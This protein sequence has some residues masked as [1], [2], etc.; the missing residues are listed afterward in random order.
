MKVLSTYYDESHAITSSMLEND[1][2]TFNIINWKTG[3]SKFFHNNVKINCESFEIIKYYLSD[4]T[5]ILIGHDKFIV[6]KHDKINNRNC[7]VKLTPFFEENFSSLSFQYK[8]I[9]YTK[10]GKLHYFEDGKSNVVDFDYDEDY[11]PN[12]IFRKGDNLL[13]FN[14]EHR[15]DIFLMTS[16]FKPRGKFISIINPYHHKLT[17]NYLCCSEKKNA[18]NEWTS[19]IKNTKIIFLMKIEVDGVIM[20][21]SN[22]FRQPIPEKQIVYCDNTYWLHY[23]EENIYE[24]SQKAMAYKIKPRNNESFYYEKK[25]IYPYEKNGVQS[26]KTKQKIISHNR[27]SL[28]FNPETKTIKIKFLIGS[29]TKY[30]FNE[31]IKSLLFF[32]IQSN[33]IYLLFTDNGTHLNIWVT[34]DGIKLLVKVNF[35]VDIIDHNWIKRIQKTAK[36]SNHPI[37]IPHHFTGEQLINVS[38]VNGG[39]ITA[40]S[41]SDVN[42]AVGNGVA[43]QFNTTINNYLITKIFSQK[44]I[45]SQVVYNENDDLLNVIL[46]LLLVFKT[47]QTITFRIPIQILS[48][49]ANTIGID[50]DN[51]ESQLTYF[52]NYEHPDNAK[53][54][55]DN[56]V[57]I[58]GY[59]SMIELLKE[60]LYFDKN[61]D[62]YF[63]KHKNLIDH[64]CE[65]HNIIFEKIPN[66]QTL[67]WFYSGEINF[68]EMK[69]KLISQLEITEFAKDK[70]IN[71]IKNLNNEQTEDF[72]FNISGVTRVASVKYNLIFKDNIQFKFIACTHTCMIPSYF[73]NENDDFIIYNLTTKITD[74]H[75]DIPA[76]L[77]NNDEINTFRISSVV[78]NDTILSLAESFQSLRNSTYGISA[79]V[80]LD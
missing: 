49:I 9:Y 60:Q 78:G 12:L 45:W 56:D 5:L 43:N 7:K 33:D 6:C 16:S 73:I 76:S 17:I 79:N 30:N 63:E 3:I 10:E 23:D 51:L 75:D 31:P 40:S 68:N 64:F 18:P 36:N 57:S 28:I 2:F 14:F 70:I 62:E 58:F 15:D 67:D 38:V 77:P 69:N 72:L 48:I 55:I 61:I 8:T 32:Y 34:N 74:I 71:I 27:S 29:K 54:L 21:D 24:V 1:N 46:Y 50:D 44:N 80:F 52:L 41:Y 66:L 26:D 4:D 35:I 42:F 11:L 13:F 22:A 53:K 20:I 47:K 59:D 39:I 25:S 19:N 37:N 65:I